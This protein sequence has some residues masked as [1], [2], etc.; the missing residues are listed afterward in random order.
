MR[1][2]RIGNDVCD[3]GIEFLGPWLMLFVGL[4]SGM[5]LTALPPARSSGI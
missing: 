5:D 1:R 4:F 2:A 3:A